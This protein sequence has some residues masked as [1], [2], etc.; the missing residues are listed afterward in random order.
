[1]AV[2]AGAKHRRHGEGE[3]QRDLVRILSYGGGG[4][5]Q[6]VID[7]VGTESASAKPDPATEIILSTGGTKKPSGC[8]KTNSSF[9]T[10]T[11]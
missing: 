3:D 9:S 8:L 4:S 11:T 2:Q 1:M 6:L 7:P 10:F 5:S